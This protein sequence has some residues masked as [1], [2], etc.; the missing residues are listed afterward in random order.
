V[1]GSS[2]IEPIFNAVWNRF[3]GLLPGLGRR[4]GFALVQRLFEFASGRGFASG[5]ARAAEFLVR[6]EEEKRLL[7]QPG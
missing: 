1:K 5:G 2:A 6:L 3:V 7:S 4:E